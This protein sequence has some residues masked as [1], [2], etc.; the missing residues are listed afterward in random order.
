MIEYNKEIKLSGKLWL[1]YQVFYDDAHPLKSSGSGKIKYHRHVASIKEGYWLP[2]ELAVH[3]ID[4]DKLNNKP[5]NL[6]VL[7]H[8]DHQ[9]LEHYMRTNGARVTDLEEINSIIISRLV[10]DYLYYCSC[11]GK[12]VARKCAT[13]LCR[14]CLSI[15]TRKFLLNKEEL[16]ALLWKIPI[17][18]IAKDNGVATSTVDKRIKL[19]GITDKPGVGYWQKLEFGKL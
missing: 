17:T 7:P 16:E 6:L 11:C 2:P 19:F 14:D 1:G 8:R 12:K 13:G 9:I 3:H 18:Q 5:E 15:S 4:G 10:D